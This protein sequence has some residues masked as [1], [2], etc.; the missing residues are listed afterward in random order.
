MRKVEEIV[1]N[2]S[3][4]ADSN[5][6]KIATLTGLGQ[7]RKGGKVNT[8]IREKPSS[9]S[10]TIVTNRR[11]NQGEMSNAMDPLYNILISPSQ[12]ETK[13]MSLTITHP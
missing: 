1:R 10:P 11:N 9:T 4:S 8:S 7:K 3:G 5:L 12:N 13:N 2:E 6:V